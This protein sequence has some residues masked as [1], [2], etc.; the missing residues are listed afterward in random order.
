MCQFFENERGSELG[1]DIN[2]L[3]FIVAA[4]A[5]GC[6]FARTVMI[7]RQRLYVARAD[8][9]RLVPSRVRCGDAADANYAEWV[10]RRLGA[11]VADAIDVSGYEGA[12]ILHDMNLPLPS[13]HHEKY[14]AV[15]ECGTLEHLF[16]VPIAI[17]NCM[18]LLAVNGRLIC[19]TVANNFCGHGFYQFSPELFFRVFQPENGFEVE[20]IVA[21]DA[22]Y[23]SEW[24][25]VVDP[26]FMKRRVE[27]VGPYPVTLLVQ[28]RKVQGMAKFRRPPQQSDYVSAW[29]GAR[30]HPDQT[31]ASRPRFSYWSLMRKWLRGRV[32]AYRSARQYRAAGLQK[33][34]AMTTELMPRQ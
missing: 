29:S 15:L 21:C 24:Y 9:E 32:R 25:T 33:V 8:I 11:E 4:G 28:A 3:K 20:R 6:D 19:C 2:A 13:A 10:L 30:L 18:D 26:Q 27:I 16:N 17:Q 31:P 5:S 34:S 22:F 12:S 14:T 7:G 23:E 1:I